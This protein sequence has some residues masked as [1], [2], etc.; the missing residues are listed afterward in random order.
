M[1]CKLFLVFAVTKAVFPLP[2]QL[3][4]YC[5]CRY[6][7]WSMIRQTCI[8]SY[9][10]F[11]DK[12]NIAYFILYLISYSK[13]SC[14]LGWAYQAYSEKYFFKLKLCTMLVNSS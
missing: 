13:Y 10:L 8:V 2:M 5:E 11:R 9:C 14:I 7:P 1:H 6:L 3:S 12:L 4:N